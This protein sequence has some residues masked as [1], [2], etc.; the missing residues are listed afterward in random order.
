M[1][2]GTSSS[3]ALTPIGSDTS[4]MFHSHHSLPIGQWVN[5]KTYMSLSEGND[6][7]LVVYVNDNE[8]IRYTG[9]TEFINGGSRYGVE[10]GK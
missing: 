1:N 5:I 7:Q 2:T 10:I 6:G 8:I 9:R 3:S 4:P